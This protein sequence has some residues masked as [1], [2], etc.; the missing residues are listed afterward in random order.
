MHSPWTRDGNDNVE[1][2]SL[3]ADRVGRVDALLTN[4]NYLGVE[5]CS[6]QR[7]VTL[8]EDMRTVRISPVE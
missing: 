1:C 3:Q 5:P 8:T 6:F 7:F 4:R 2:A